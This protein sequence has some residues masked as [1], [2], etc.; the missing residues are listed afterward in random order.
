[1]FGYRRLLRKGST[2]ITMEIYSILGIA[3]VRENKEMK[4]FNLIHWKVHLNIE[5]ELAI[6]VSM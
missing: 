5:G 6:A 2:L 4:R 1:M 3:L